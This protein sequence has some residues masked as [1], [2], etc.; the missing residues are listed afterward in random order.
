MAEHASP[1]LHKLG[2]VQTSVLVDVEHVDRH[3]IIPRC[4]LKSTTDISIN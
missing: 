4:A 2:L 1:Q 3:S